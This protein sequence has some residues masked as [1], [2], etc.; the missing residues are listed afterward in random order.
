MAVAEVNI[1]SVETV[2]EFVLRRERHGTPPSEGFVVD[3]YMISEQ[4]RTKLPFR[5]GV[6]KGQ[7]D[8]LPALRH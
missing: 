2:C 6:N 8:L 7:N 5:T 4:H 3:I 1:A